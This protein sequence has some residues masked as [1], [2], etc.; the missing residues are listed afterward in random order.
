MT[1]PACMEASVRKDGIAT[2]VTV[3]KQ[4]FQGPHVE[5]VSRNYVCMSQQRTIPTSNPLASYYFL[6]FIHSF[7][8]GKKKPRLKKKRI[9]KQYLGFS[10]D[11]FS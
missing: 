6:S 1:V 9:S 4:A 7:E 3:R 11:S 10:F 5:M 2:F 8:T